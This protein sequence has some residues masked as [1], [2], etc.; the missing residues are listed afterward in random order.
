MEA[1]VKPEKASNPQER[2]ALPITETGRRSHFHPPGT[3][4]ADGG[5][6]VTYVTP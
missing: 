3:I 2:A 6:V 5:D 1:F 4:E